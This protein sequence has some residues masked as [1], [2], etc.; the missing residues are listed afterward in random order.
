MEKSGAKCD[1]A[2]KTLIALVGDR[3]AQDF[4]Q[5]WQSSHQAEL[6]APAN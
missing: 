5:L 1:A 3:G 6:T 4:V 2:K